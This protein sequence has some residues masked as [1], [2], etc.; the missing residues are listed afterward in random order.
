MVVID[1]A[2]ADFIE[3]KDTLRKEEFLNYHPSVLIVRTFSK[4]L[5]LAGLRLGYGIG[6]EEIISFLDKVRQPF[7]INILAVKAGIAV[8]E[9]RDYILKCKQTIITGRNYL[10][11]NFQKLGFKVIPS[12]ANFIMV[13]FGEK[14]KEIYN[15]LLKKGF[16]I[17]PLSPYGFDNWFRISIGLPEENKALI[18]TISQILKEI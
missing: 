13:Y 14:G 11:N 17:R 10:I 8:L 1:E 7:N 9:D 15:N 5:G 4:S 18:D 12:Q 6:R 3:E 2:Y 16:L